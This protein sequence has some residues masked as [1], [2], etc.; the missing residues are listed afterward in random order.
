MNFTQWL[1]H[2]LSSPQVRCYSDRQYM[3]LLAACTARLNEMD[4]TPAERKYVY[5]KRASAKYDRI[6]MIYKDSTGNSTV[7][8]ALVC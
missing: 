5:N 6:D 7:G 4:I 1:S 3:L 8:A 2:H